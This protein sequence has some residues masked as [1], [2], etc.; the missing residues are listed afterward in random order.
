MIP[1]NCGQRERLAHWRW[2]VTKLGIRLWL[3][4]GNR[5]KS[6]DSPTYLTIW[7]V[8]P[9]VS[10]ESLLFL[11]AFTLQVIM[12]SGVLWVCCVY[13]CICM[14]FLPFDFCSLFC[15]FVIFWFVCLYL[16]FPYV[17]SVITTQHLPRSH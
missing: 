14:C 12:A 15:F 6:D 3:V 1:C 9:V 10:R 5:K 16:I 7:T 8:W 11:F 13:L 17:D 2:F 4:S